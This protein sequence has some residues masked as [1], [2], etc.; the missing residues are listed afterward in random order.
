MENRN[1][2]IVDAELT[3]AD[4]HAER[5]TALEML[6]R[7][8]ARARRRTVAADKGYDTKAFV[9]DCRNLGVTPHVA[10]HTNGRRSAT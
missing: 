10:P 6:K 8:P 1:A 3:Q 2:L 7:L 5:A 4:G 9:A